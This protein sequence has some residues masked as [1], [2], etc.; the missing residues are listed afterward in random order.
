MKDRKRINLFT[1][2]Y[3]L[4]MLYLL[5]SLCS[6]LF[7]ILIVVE[8]SQIVVYEITLTNKEV[9]FVSFEDCCPLSINTDKKNLKAVQ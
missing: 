9:L 3:F 2:F 1:I 4:M 6:V 8:I 7:I 5:F